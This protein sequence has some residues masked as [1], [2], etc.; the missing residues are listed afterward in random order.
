[1]KNIIPTLII[2]IL[3][4]IKKI[5]IFIQ[6][7]PPATERC[8]RALRHHSPFHTYPLSEDVNNSGQKGAGKVTAV[9]IA[10]SPTQA[11]TPILVCKAWLNCDAQSPLCILYSYFAFTMTQ[12]IKRLEPQ[13]TLFPVTVDF[14][15]LVSVENFLVDDSDPHSHPNPYCELARRGYQCFDPSLNNIRN[16]K[17]IDLDFCMPWFLKYFLIPLLQVGAR[18]AHHSTSTSTRTYTPL[19]T[20]TKIHYPDEF[21]RNLGCYYQLPSPRSIPYFFLRQM[22]Q[23]IKSS[24]FKI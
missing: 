2:L 6:E 10:H 23:F 18:A 21:S 9:T 3:I 14:L 11:Q 8:R 4:I 5:H 12:F 20:Y 17:I 24:I 15:E 7:L 22:F 16:G 19:K 1:M 13:L